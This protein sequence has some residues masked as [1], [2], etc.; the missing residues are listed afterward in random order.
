MN[1]ACFCSYSSMIWENVVFHQTDFTQ[2]CSWYLGP[3]HTGN[4]NSAHLEVDNV[5]HK[6]KLNNNIAACRLFPVKAFGTECVPFFVHMIHLWVLPKLLST[7]NHSLPC[8]LIQNDGLIDIFHKFTLRQYTCSSILQYY[9]NP[10]KN[11]GTLRGH[12]DVERKPVHFRA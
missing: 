3:T 7:T 4:Y 5:L 8:L 12:S 11:L 1:F 9:I 6:Q 10:S 2:T